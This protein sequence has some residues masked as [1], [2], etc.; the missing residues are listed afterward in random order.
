MTPVTPLRGEERAWI[1][2][3]PTGRLIRIARTSST[4]V[5]SRPSGDGLRAHHVTPAL[6]I[7]AYLEDA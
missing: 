1:A 5:A 4:W 6:A 3:A 7:R 2:R